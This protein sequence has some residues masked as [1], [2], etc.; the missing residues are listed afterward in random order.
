MSKRNK[1]LEQSLR[2]EKVRFKLYKAGKHWIKAGLKEIELLRIM[3]M[4]F[5]NKTVEKEVKLEVD[6]TDDL[7]KDFIKKTA[8]VGGAFATM[9][10]IDGHQAFAASET[11]ITS[12]LSSYKPNSCESKF[13]IVNCLIYK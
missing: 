4:P 1:K 11:P 5:T 8:I 2:E 13:N 12:E 7:K 3:G 10:L 9:N 6:T